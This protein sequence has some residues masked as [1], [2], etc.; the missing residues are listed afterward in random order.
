MKDPSKNPNVKRKNSKPILGVV[1]NIFKLDNLLTEEE[2]AYYIAQTEKINYDD[3]SDI[4]FEY[5]KHYR[6]NKR[7]ICISEELADCLWK[8]IEPILL[9]SDI[10]NVTPVGWGT[11]GRWQPTSLN[12]CFLFSRYEEGEFFKAHFDGMYRNEHDECS[13]YTVSI[14]LNDDYKGGDLVFHH[15]TTKKPTLRLKPNAGSAL[16]FN[17]DVL[18]EGEEVKAG[19][20]YVVRTSIMFK[21]VE[22][23][24]DPQR[25]F[26]QNTLWQK[27]KKTFSDFT[28][29]AMQGDTEKF[30]NKYIEAQSMQIQH[31]GTIHPEPDSDIP[32]DILLSIFSYLTPE[33]LCGISLVSK[34]WHLASRSGALW[35]QLYSI[36]WGSGC[37]KIIED[38]SRLVDPEL[39]DWYGIFKRRHIT[40]AKTV[41]L[42]SYLEEDLWGATTSEKKSSPAFPICPARAS[43]IYD[44]WDYSF[45]NYNIGVGD[46]WYEPSL[47][48]RLVQELIAYSF[49][50]LKCA[51]DQHTLLIIV[52]PAIWI[53]QKGLSTPITNINANGKLIAQIEK[54][55]LKELSECAVKLLDIRALSYVD[56]GICALY[57]KGLRSGVVMFLFFKPSNVVETYLSAYS[58]CGIV[59]GAQ[60]K[61][62][63]EMKTVQFSHFK[64]ELEVV[65]SAVGN[66]ELGK[67]V[68]LVIVNPSRDPFKIWTNLEIEAK[69]LGYDLSLANSCDIIQGGVNFASLPEFKQSYVVQ[70]KDFFFS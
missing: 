8:R 46:L 22:N 63:R 15:P 33:K 59:K 9:Y 47:Q 3:A 21:K 20:K 27:M 57:S 37:L 42:V 52:L 62:V 65:Y 30:T 69:K 32:Y 2:C 24:A 19:R 68:L 4:S 60:R 38:P 58:Q 55:Y 23:L 35:R 36:R 6:N 10:R 26:E 5:P 50:K 1:Q 49:Y 13:I 64:E 51:S 12:K 54:T 14:Y 39:K 31:S 16:V 29:L 48:T 41:T 7:L 56:A 11:S 43:R 53:G 17:H 44:P 61:Y 67:T 18:H 28:K 66:E 25:P 70:A 40:Q 34:A 45:I